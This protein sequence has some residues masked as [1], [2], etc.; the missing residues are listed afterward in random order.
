[1]AAFNGPQN[2]EFPSLGSLAAAD[3]LSLSHPL[4]LLLLGGMKASILLYYME[5]DR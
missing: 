1:M 5:E 3:G 2:G 4:L